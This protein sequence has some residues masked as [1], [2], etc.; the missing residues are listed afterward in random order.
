[1]NALIESSME[2]RRDDIELGKKLERERILKVLKPHAEHD[3]WCKDGGCYPEDCSAGIVQYLIDKILET[4]S[5][6]NVNNT[7]QEALECQE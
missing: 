7:G 5:Q 6:E 4:N 3:D 1:M 2:L